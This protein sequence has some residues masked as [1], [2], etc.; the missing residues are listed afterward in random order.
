MATYAPGEAQVIPAANLQRSARLRA[1]EELERDLR[2]ALE[3]EV[4][5]DQG[6]RAMYSVDASNY[7]HVPVGV[8]VPASQEDAIAAV[9]VCR[10]HDVPIVARAGGT[11][12]A[13]QTV[14][15]AVVLDFSRYVNRILSLDP[16]ARI[17]RVEPG[18]ICDTLADA[19]APHSLTW[20]PQPATHSHCCFGGMLGNNACGAHAQMAGKAV[21][22]TEALRVL[23]YDGTVMEVG[24]M[25]DADLEAAIAAG[26]REGQVYSRLKALRSRWGDAVR[27]RFPRLPRRVSGYN[28]DQL[29]PGPDG[30]FNIARALVGSENTLVTILDATVRLVWNHPKRV[31][32]VAGYEDI[33]RA[34]DAVPSVLP[35]GPIGLEGMDDILVENMRIK[36]ARH[37]QAIRLLPR[38][39]GWLLVEF[40]EA[41]TEAALD[42]ARACVATL[43]RQSHRPLGLEVL[44]DVPHMKALWE[45]REAGLGATA[46]VPGKP[47]AW[48]GWE[49]S[50]VRPEYLGNYL[51]DLRTLYDRY[52][53]HPALYG[54]FGMG[55]VHCR[56]DFDL[57]TAQGVARFKAFLREAAELVTRYGGSLSGE[58]GDGQARSELLPIMFGPSLVEAFREFKAIWDPEGRMN[59]GRIVDPL[60][61]DRDLRL[62]ADYDPRE[63]NTYFRYPEDGGSFA[64]AT[65]RCVGIGRCRRLGGGK[66][67]AE[68]V[69]CPSFMVTREERHSTRGRAH[70]LH[71][72]LTRKEPQVIEGGW[73]SEEVKEA[74]DLCL[75][76]KGCK[77][78]CPVSVDMATY[79]AE[80]LAHYY[81]GRLHPRSH[82]AFGFVDRWAQIASFAPGFVNL[83]TQTPGL[84]V[85]A[86]IA[87][88]MPLARRIPT[89]AP[90]TFRSWFQARGRR[91]AGQRKVV[92]WADTFNNYFHTEVA[93]DAVHVLEDA[94][95]EV[96]VPEGHLC[97]GR[98]LYD[99]GFLTAA[100][101][102]LD[103]VL[104]AMRPHIEA[105]TP[106]VVLE[107][108]CA[109]VFR[110]ELI[111]LFPERPEAKALAGQTMLLSEYLTKH[112]DGWVPPRLERK[113][114]VQGHC[115]HKSVLGFDEEKELLGRMGLDF[116][117][118]QSSCCGLAGSFGFERGDK[119]RVSVAEGERVLFPAV[120]EAEPT[121]LVVAD[122][123]SCKT[124]IEQGTRRGALHL[125]EVLAMAI[126]RPEAT[127]GRP[128][129]R[130]RRR[131]KM[132]IAMSMASAALGVAAVA[133]GS[134]AIAYLGARGRRL[135]WGRGRRR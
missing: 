120:R 2:A 118:L 73:R 55:C 134:L 43:N 29:L 102:Y 59:P 122:G 45:V 21:D 13:G 14:N 74:L 92:L 23:L 104:A 8:V 83:L 32:V 71:E 34:A 41:T 79:K 91:N 76:C 48:P 9:A 70:L 4:R 116:E 11:G 86:K 68:D 111:G 107:P 78:D 50:A 28:L 72:M 123:F 87:A 25:N 35:F 40:G 128:E 33:F 66:S 113:A 56:V 105:R 135:R 19:A 129:A 126:D 24:W 58:H 39:R 60:P 31:L 115:H 82:Y 130:G 88:G 131:R 101:T 46:F 16:G 99:Y 96:V 124:Q 26:G 36:H 100:K 15:R 67:E 37:E 90:R 3:G 18:V 42:R 69:M 6:S 17:A 119:Y 121:T 62:G 20:G 133:V 108:S 27:E 38:G 77:G 95:C 125:A 54:H 57:Y 51:R 89:F 97:C 22:N 61:V 81:E 114:I 93:K 5:F 63:P 106:I 103:R 10:A 7:R 65:L 1:T 117:V 75:S 98:P 127:S 52:D 132:E 80:F 53:Y 64:R 30:R 12:L 85:V 44:T 49:D 47:D 94:R 110:D 109:S 112:S 84:D